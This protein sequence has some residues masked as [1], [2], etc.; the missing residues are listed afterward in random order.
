MPSPPKIIE[1]ACALS[2]AACASSTINVAATAPHL[3][4]CVPDSRGIFAPILAAFPTLEMSVLHLAALSDK[5]ENYS[6][7]SKGGEYGAF[8]TI[9]KDF[10][11]LDE[12]DFAPP[13]I[14]PTLRQAF[15]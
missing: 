4:A 9:E 12:F 5:S 2:I 14:A 8:V 10:W 6:A 13:N 3:A 15:P 11:E 7:E 1:A